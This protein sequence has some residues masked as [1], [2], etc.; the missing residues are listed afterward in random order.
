MNAAFVPLST[1]SRFGPVVPLVPACESVWQAPHGVAP[2]A[3]LPLVKIAL[4]T[5]DA[6]GPLPPWRPPPASPLPPPPFAEALV[7]RTQVVK[8]W[9]FLALTD[10]RMKAW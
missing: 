8:P 2:V 5:G 1:W 7:R 10:E 6:A 3:F 9:V 4:A